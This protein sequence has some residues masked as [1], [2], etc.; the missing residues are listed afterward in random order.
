MITTIVNGKEYDLATTLRVAYL[1][2]GQHNH[3]PYSEVFSGI[4]D[5]VLEDQIGILYCAFK[6]A[7][8]DE[9]KFIK[10]EDFFNSYLDN[11]TLKEVMDQLEK[12]IKGIMV[13]RTRPRMPR[14]MLTPRTRTPRESKSPDLVGPV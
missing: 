4:G 11:F 1:V 5:M 8:P 7:N 3:K 2:Q 12:V 14:L 9:A 13:L 10:R 6:V